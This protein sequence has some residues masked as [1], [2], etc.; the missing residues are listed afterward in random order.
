MF[1]CVIRI[2]QTHI[3]RIM[4]HIFLRKCLQPIWLQSTFNNTN[5]S[6]SQCRA[7]GM[8]FLCLGINW[9]IPVCKQSSAQLILSC[10]SETFGGNASA[11]S[12]IKPYACRLTMQNRG[13]DTRYIRPLI[14]TKCVH[15]NCYFLINWACGAMDNASDYGSEDSRFESWQA[16]KEYFF[17]ISCR[18][19]LF[20]SFSASALFLGLLG[21]TF[22]LF[23]LLC[24]DKDP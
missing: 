3:D 11:I 5:R 16:Q 19:P 22:R 15:I 23:K 18:Y 4:V 6:P 7:S 17:F 2:Y 13:K 12:P 8:E 1:I 10:N 9:H 14:S 24:L 20:L 21:I